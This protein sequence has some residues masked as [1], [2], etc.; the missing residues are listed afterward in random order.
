MFAL[1]ALDAKR[2][3]PAGATQ[4]VAAWPVPTESIGVTVPSESS[5]NVD[6]AFVPASA[7]TRWPAWSK[8]IANG[9]GRAR[10]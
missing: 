7:M 5:V 9:T 1:P 10:R 8:V 2:V 6:S 4:Q 3:P